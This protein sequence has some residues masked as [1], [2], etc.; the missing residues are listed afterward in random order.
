MKKLSECKH[1]E[2]HPKRK[3]FKTGIYAGVRLRDI[4]TEYLTW[5]SNNAYKHMENR[6]EWVKEELKNRLKP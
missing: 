2:Y 4:P 6:L 3:P 1:W 5:F